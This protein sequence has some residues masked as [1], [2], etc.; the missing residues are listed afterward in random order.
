MLFGHAKAAED[1]PDVLGPPSVW[2]EM[3]ATH[4]ELHPL[5]VLVP[6]MAVLGVF[7]YFA[8]R[9]IKKDTFPEVKAV[10]VAIL[11]FGRM[12]VQQAKT[13][14]QHDPNTSSQ[15]PTGTSAGMP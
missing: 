15:L 14:D 11:A 6:M 7:V 12:R 1:L 2:V 10:Q 3:L 9:Q 13:H 4:G 5:V 8:V